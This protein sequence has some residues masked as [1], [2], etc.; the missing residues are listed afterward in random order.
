MTRTDCTQVE[1]HI[2]MTKRWAYQMSQAIPVLLMLVGLGVTPVFAQ[3]H[4]SHAHETHK[5]E[6]KTPE[7][8]KT[9]LG[10]LISIRDHQQELHEAIEANEL[11]EV[12]HIAFTVRDLVAALPGKSKLSGEQKKVLKKSVTR[13]DSLATMLDEAG[14]AGDS[15]AVALLVGRFDVEIQGVE[16]LYTLKDVKPAATATA[17]SKPM[18]VCPMHPD[19][20]SDKASECSKCGMDLVKKDH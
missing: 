13:V 17:A 5:E 14:D 18:Y 9:L 3:D 1:S 4:G 7:L 8:P 15:T 16:A 2:M 12:H 11:E 6:T 10:L 20:T 19:I